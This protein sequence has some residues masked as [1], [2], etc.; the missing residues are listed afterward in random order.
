MTNFVAFGDSMTVGVIALRTP[1]FALMKLDDSQTYPFK[2][3]ALLIG[4]YTAQSFVV[5]NAGVSGEWAQ[6]GQKRLPGVLAGSHPQVLCLMEGA[7]DLAGGKSS[8]QPAADAIE[9]MVKLATRSGVKVLLA[10]IPP[11]KPG[12][13]RGLAS[14]LV[15]LLN[16]EIAKTARSQGVPLVDVFGAFGN[17]YSLLSADGLHPSEAGYERIAETFFARIQAS[18]ELPAS[19]SLRR[20]S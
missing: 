18:F 16:T 9:N 1:E 14:D 6:D 12:T 13:S 17:D 11:Q 4:R 20:H 8:I 3:Q 2:L 15:P 19:S 7:N 5:V 10:T